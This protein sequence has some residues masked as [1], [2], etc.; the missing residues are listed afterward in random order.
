ME[1]TEKN[2]IFAS[3]WTPTWVYQVTI[4]LLW[5]ATYAVLLAFS[6]ALHDVWCAVCFLTLLLAYP[7]FITGFVA[8]AW[9][10]A[11]REMFTVFGFL[12][13]VLG[14]LLVMEYFKNKSDISYL[15]TLPVLPFGMWAIFMWS[16]C[17]SFWVVVPKKHA[18]CRTFFISTIGIL[19]ACGITCCIDSSWGLLP[20]LVLVFFWLSFVLLLFMA[21]IAICVERKRSIKKNKIE[22][23]SE[24]E[25]ENGMETI[26]SVVSWRAE[27]CVA[28][29]LGTLFYYVLSGF[30]FWGL[31]T[32]APHLSD[33][34]E[35]VR[36]CL[37]RVNVHVPETATWEKAIHAGFQDRYDCAL[38]TMTAEDFERIQLPEGVTW[39]KPKDIHEVNL[40]YNDMFWTPAFTEE[41]LKRDFEAGRV[42]IFNMSSHESI[43]FPGGV[44]CFD[45]KG[46]N[47]RVW[48]CNRGI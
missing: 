31:L 44:A 13:L 10:N 32:L 2:G 21:W 35:S 34:R 6:S 28:G 23:K 46:E 42:R 18:I 9:K 48:L 11:L 30:M 16:A 33:S 43:F 37:K 15:L 3:A 14:V 27:A 25:M 22:N 45:E 12:A 17:R 7:I 39:E 4:T 29:C 41:E 47:V 36:E 1:T 19:T 26:P 40:V 38:L 8:P 24:N 20:I 5:C